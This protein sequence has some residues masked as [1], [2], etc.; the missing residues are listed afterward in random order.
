MEHAAGRAR[1]ETR[2]IDKR[3]ITK[4]HNT[5]DHITGVEWSYHQT[6]I[7]ISVSGAES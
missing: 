4:E 5:K 7:G 1:R 2:H 6:G 3:H